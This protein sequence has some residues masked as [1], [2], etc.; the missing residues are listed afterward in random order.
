MLVILSHTRS[1]GHGQRQTYQRRLRRFNDIK[2]P[3]CASRQW[4]TGTTAYQQSLWGEPPDI[5]ECYCKECGKSFFLEW[6]ERTPSPVQDPSPI[7]EPG[8]RETHFGLPRKAGR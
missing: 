1:G 5:E 8:R 2:C 4:A 6:I 7:E 3:D